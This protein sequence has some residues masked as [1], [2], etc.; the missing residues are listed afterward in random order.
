M[1]HRTYRNY[2]KFICLSLC[3]FVASIAIPKPV[4]STSIAMVDQIVYFTPGSAEIREIDIPI[5]KD[6][7]EIMKKAYPNL[8]IVIEGHA[9]ATESK[10]KED[11]LSQKRAQAVKDYLVSLGIDPS[12]LML[13]WHGASL[14][15]STNKTKDGRA[16]NRRVEFKTFSP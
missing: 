7:S 2:K 4:R 16:H 8:K 15:T 1:S 3:L 11:T 14:P 12:R 6:V 9:D 5:L 10:G 13:D